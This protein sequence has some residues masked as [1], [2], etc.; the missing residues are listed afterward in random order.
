[1]ATLVMV[2]VT[3]GQI[4]QLATFPFHDDTG[5]YASTVYVMAGANLFHL[6]LTVFI[7]LGIWN[8]ARLGLFSA[9]SHWQVRITNI[10]WS[11]IALAALIGA[12]TTSFIASP[13]VGG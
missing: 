7:G 5:S 12:L 13:H 11:W 8:R 2:G 10:W 9:A 6:L 4:I 3:V 1:L